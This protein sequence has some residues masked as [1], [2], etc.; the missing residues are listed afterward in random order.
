MKGVGFDLAYLSEILREQQ[1]VGRQKVCGLP[2]EGVG[3]GAETLRRKV[4]DNSRNEGSGKGNC[5]TGF[6]EASDY[7]VLAPLGVSSH[8]IPPDDGTYKWIFPGRSGCQVS[9]LPQGLIQR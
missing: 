9:C 8:S 3:G 5:S 1:G 2:Q 6:V 4:P 7:W